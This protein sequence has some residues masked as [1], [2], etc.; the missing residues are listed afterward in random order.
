MQ[1]SILNSSFSIP[2]VAFHPGE[3][4]SRQLTIVIGLTVVGFMAFGLA[5]S[6]YRN[7]LFDQTLGDMRKQNAAM[8]R[9]NDEARR[10]LEYMNSL[11]HKDKYA[12][13]NLGRV[14]EHEKV[15]IITPAL[16]EVPFGEELDASGVQQQEARFLELLR[17]MPPLEHWQLFLFQPERVEE[18]RRGV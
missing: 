15:L 8:A 11:Q 4:L 14:R 3:P 5:L 16:Q 7:I 1:F 12:K 18:L 13:E 6:F 9:R 17:Q 10:E 2:L